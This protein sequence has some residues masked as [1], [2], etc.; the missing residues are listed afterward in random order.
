MVGVL[1]IDKP[2]GQTSHDVVNTVRKLTGQRRVGHG[3][4]LDPFATG[5]LVV[6]VGKATRLLEYTRRLHKTYRTTFVLGTTSDTDDKTGVIAAGPSTTV[7]EPA[8]KAITKAL[9]TFLGNIEQLPPA[10]SAV[11]IDGKRMYELARKG[12]TVAA[13]ARHVTIYDIKLLRYEYP[14]LELEITCSGGTY[15]RAIA[16]DLGEKLGVGGYAKELRRLAIGT[17]TAEHAV[18]LD[19]LTQENINQHLQAP[20]VLA[21]HL[22]HITLTEEQLQDFQQGKKIS[23]TQ[24]VQPAERPLAVF[25]KAKHLIGIGMVADNYLQPDKV[26]VV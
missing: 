25:D 2:A 20:E 21:A 16:R 22:P 18:T 14:E 19:A 6:A 7:T 4:T 8:K 3:G 26:L 24:S 15:I 13:E 9:K 11:K 10:Y 23:I 1:N 12:Q 5:V 17:F